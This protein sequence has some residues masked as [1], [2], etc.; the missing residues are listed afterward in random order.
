MN[1]IIAKVHCDAAGVK[2][3]QYSPSYKPEKIELS[4][5]QGQTEEDRIFQS[6]TPGGEIK[7][8]IINESAKG[9]FKP[10][11]KYFVTFEEAAE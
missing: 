8:D 5:V 7:L 1:K 11:K 9:F 6:S 3:Q 2:V 4:V 10:G